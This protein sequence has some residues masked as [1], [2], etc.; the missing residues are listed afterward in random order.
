MPTFRTTVS[1]LLLFSATCSVS[2]CTSWD[3]LPTCAQ[4]C[5]EQAFRAVAPQ[6]DDG[7]VDPLAVRRCACQSCTYFNTLS[8]CLHQSGG[9]NDHDLTEALQANNS[10]FCNMS[11]GAGVIWA[12]NNS[13]WGVGSSFGTTSTSF[14]LTCATATVVSTTWVSVS[15]L[16][17]M[18]TRSPPL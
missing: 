3:G 18:E 12:S 11:V 7:E 6:C 13:Q 17:G 1:I 5:F 8:S 16:S 15:L 14:T 10:V 4:S 2:A 9:C